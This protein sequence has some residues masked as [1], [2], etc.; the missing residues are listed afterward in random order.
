MRGV[1]LFP[2]LLLSFSS[3]VAENLSVDLRTDKE[4]QSDVRK[5]VERA[6]LNC[7]VPLAYSSTGEDHRGVISKIDCA[8]KDG[9]K[10]WSFRNIAPPGHLSR[11]EPW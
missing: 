2:I 1:Q 6:G 3:A 7:P 8:S 4:F 9:S 11:L 5:R 10:T